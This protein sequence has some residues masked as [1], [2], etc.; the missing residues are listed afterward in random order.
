MSVAYLQHP[1]MFTAPASPSN[2]YQYP[3]K[4]QQFTKQQKQCLM[5]R[6]DYQQMM[7]HARSMESGLGK[8]SNHFFDRRFES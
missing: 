6:R 7:W 8:H 3:I 5:P 2:N 1:L 4:Q